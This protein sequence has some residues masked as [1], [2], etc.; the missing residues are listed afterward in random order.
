MLEGTVTHIG[1]DASEGAAARGAQGAR[2]VPGA[3]SADYR[4]LIALNQASV[5]RSTSQLKLSAGMQVTAEIHQGERT[6]L[7]YV[8]SPVQKTA[9]E[10]GR[11][12]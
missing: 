4:L 1:P 10:A 2:S 8:L 6:V 11:E 9:Y 7:D 12:R 5:E 3:S